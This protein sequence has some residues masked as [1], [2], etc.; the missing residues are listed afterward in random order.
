MEIVADHVRLFLKLN[1]STSSSKVIEYLKGCSSRQLFK[2]HPELKKRYWGG[3]TQFDYIILEK[4][5]I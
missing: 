4:F 3:S 5:K 1:P 2:L